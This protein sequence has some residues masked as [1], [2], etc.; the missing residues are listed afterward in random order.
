[1]A[2]TERGPCAYCGNERRKP[3]PLGVVMGLSGETANLL[4]CHECHK[5]IHDHFSVS[6]AIRVRLQVAVEEAAFLRG[7][8]SE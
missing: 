4:V 8:A 5:F 7:T 6:R 3:I 1:M 2:V